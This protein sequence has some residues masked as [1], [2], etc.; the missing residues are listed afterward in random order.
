MDKILE[1][2][3]SIESDINEMKK[4]ISNI[5]KDNNKMSNHIDFVDSIYD[6]IKSPFHY[7]LNSVERMRLFQVFESRTSIIDQC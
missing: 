5:K 7:I 6:K 2:L 4:D 3:I 1:K